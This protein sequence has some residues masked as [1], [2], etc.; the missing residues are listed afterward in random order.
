MFFKDTIA[1]AKNTYK[2]SLDVGTL[3]KTAEAL[4]EI[5]NSPT[6]YDEFKMQAQGLWYGSGRKRKS[7]T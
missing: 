3:D 5:I 7:R 1:S 2:T 4:L 6:A